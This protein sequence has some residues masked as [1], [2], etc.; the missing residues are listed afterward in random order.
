[1][2][3]LQSLTERLATPE[4]QSVEPITACENIISNMPQRPIIEHGG[5]RAYYLPMFDTVCVPQPLQFISMEEFYATVYHEVVHSTGHAS[6]LAR[7]E[8]IDGAKFA[9]HA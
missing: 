5:D 1:S 7:P 3:L 8:V 9:S 6:R 4:P 2:S